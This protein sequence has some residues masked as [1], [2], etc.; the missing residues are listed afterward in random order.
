M[1]APDLAEY[2]SCSVKTATRIMKRHPNVRYLPQREGATG[3]RQR[4]ILSIDD[5]VDLYR[6]MERGEKL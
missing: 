1:R 2:I 6:R 4:P 5:C 3:Q